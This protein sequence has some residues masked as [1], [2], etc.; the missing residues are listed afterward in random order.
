MD[1][2]LAFVVEYLRGE[3]GGHSTS[4]SRGIAVTARRGWRSGPACTVDPGGLPFEQGNRF[5]RPDYPLES[6]VVAA[7]F[8]TYA[9]AK[10]LR[11]AGFDERQAGAAVA[12][13]RDAVTEGAAIK[14]D[15]VRLETL[16]ER[17]VNR[18]L[19]AIIAAV[20]VVIAAVKLLP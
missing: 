2:K 9:A 16:V 18:V 4:G 11:E 14:A 20:A 6:I 3:W 17:S 15:I 19:L 8:D 7:A 10:L 5:S 12:V 1:E 13:V